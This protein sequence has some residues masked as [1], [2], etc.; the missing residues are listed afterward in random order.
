MDPHHGRAPIGAEHHQRRLLH[1]LPDYLVEK[2]Q[3]REDPPKAIKKQCLLGK[4]RD[5]IQ[6]KVRKMVRI[7]PHSVSET[8]KEP[9]LLKTNGSSI[10]SLTEMNRLTKSANA[11]KTRITPVM[12][13]KDALM[14]TWEKKITL[15]HFTVVYHVA[16]PFVES[17]WIHNHLKRTLLT[18]SHV[19]ANASSNTS[20]APN[21]IGT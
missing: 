10:L 6:I 17:V 1:D 18:R 8:S 9:R 14:Y 2:V 21:S 15:P 3:A 13:E 7:Q 4:E 20:S 12:K 11:S 5:M 19:A 16:T